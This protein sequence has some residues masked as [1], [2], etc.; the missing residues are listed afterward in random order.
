MLGDGSYAPFDYSARGSHSCRELVSQYE[1][2]VNFTNCNETIAPGPPSQVHVNAPNT[3]SDFGFGYNI[4]VDWVDPPCALGK[5][6][7]VPRRGLN[8]ACM[9]IM[10]PS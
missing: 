7:C 9:S 6:V 3:A 4:G 10:V 8:L 2:I 1:F 5:S